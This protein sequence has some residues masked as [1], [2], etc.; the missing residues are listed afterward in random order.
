MTHRKANRNN[1][2][3]LRLTA[4]GVLAAT[5]TL[6]A[7]SSIDCPVQN[8]VYTAYGLYKPGGERDTLRDTLTILTTRRDGTDSVLLNRSVNTTAFELPMS[9]TAPADTLLFTIT[10]T[11]Q[12]TL[13][14]TVWIAKDN[15]PHFESVDCN[16]SFF[17]FITSVRW[18]GNAIDSIAVNKQN[19]DYDASTEHFHLYLKARH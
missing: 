19:V 8:T 14:D 17:H 2:A 13:T 18:T 5:L 9:Y 15:Y 7:C 16:I 1:A 10:D 6:G 3:P 11:L 12:R 4:M